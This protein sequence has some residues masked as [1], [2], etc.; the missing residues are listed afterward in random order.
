MATVSIDK[1]RF[2]AALP[3]VTSDLRLAGLDGSVRVFR[4]RHG[5]PHVRAV[6]AHDAFFGQGFVTAQDRLWHMDYD[7]HRAYGRWAELVG[8]SAV[9]EDKV[10]RRFQIGPTVRRDYDAVNVETRGM[11][12]AYAAGVN[13]FIETSESM[14]IEYD[15]VG[16]RPESWEPWDCLAVFKVRHIMMGV[17]EGK[18][19]RAKLANTLGVEKTAE[20][21]RGYQPGHL[22]IVPPG[23]DYDAPELDGLKEL[24]SGL[25]AISWLRQDPEAG[26]NSWVLSGSRTASGKPLLAGDPHRGLDTPNV[27]YQNHVE[28]PDF[29]VIGLSFPGCPG[30]PHFGH[31]SGVAWCVTHAG[32]DYQDLFLERFRVNGETRY[33]YK[34]EWL[35]ADVRREVMEVRGEESVEMD[36][37]VTRHG[38]VIAGDPAKGNAIS[39]RYT[40]T[41]E[42]NLG[43]E[44]LPRMMRARSA[45][46]LDESMRAWIDPCNNLLFADVDGNIAYL[47]RGQVPIRSMADAP[48]SRCLGGRETTSGMA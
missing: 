45:D 46:D 23:T 1:Q 48:G 14:P 30:F 7:R 12:D 38:P 41:A 25:E 32:A 39:F 2:A 20:L 21:I 43:F 9:A 37:T 19:W 22:L 47:N 36:V 18:L 8:P 3:D 29:D 28:C 16:A 34:G 13:A 6:S 31:N 27:Y 15:L 33:E 17:F 4:D 24:E 44:A 35:P 5:I 11:L 42:P 26:S 40:A 10:M